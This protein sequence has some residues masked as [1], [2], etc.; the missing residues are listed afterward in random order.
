MTE[1]INK[2]LV[3][4][5]K[6]TVNFLY[7]GLV[8]FYPE[9]VF[10]SKEGKRK[11]VLEYWP[12]GGYS[13]IEFAKLLWN[14]TKTNDTVQAAQ[15]VIDWK[16]LLDNNQPLEATVPENLDAMV[17]SLE[18]NV[19]SKK[20][21]SQYDIKNLA[22][23]VLLESEKVIEKPSS[24]PEPEIAIS[25]AETISRAVGPL[26]TFAGKILTTP[27]RAATYISGPTTYSSSAK[28]EGPSVTTAR[29]M[30][31]HGI[32]SGSIRSLENRA[33]QLGIT[34]NQLRNLASLIKTEQETHPFSYK[35]ISVIYSGQKASLS[36]AQI[37]SLL[38]PSTDGSTAVL[39]GKSFVGNVL[40][41]IGQQLFGKLTS[42]ALK[43][44]GK[45]VAAK[46]ATTAA[47]QTIATAIA[48]LV[49]NIIAFVSEKI[50]GKI[51]EKFKNL[52]SKLKT[53]EGKEN[54]L[55]LI[56]GLMAIGGIIIGGPA[57]AVLVV[58]GLVPG[59]GLLV[60]KAGGFGPLG[61]S[62]GGYGQAFMAGVTGVL[63][64][65]IGMPT[66]VALVSVP[67]LIAV[68]LFI[69]NSGAYI[70]PPSPGQI[71][72]AIESPYIGIEK[73]ANP[74]KMENLSGQAT[75]TY[76]VKIFAKKGT[77]TNISITNEYKIISESSPA[78]PNPQVEE[79]KNPPKTISPTED[80]EFQYQISVG[81][82]YN[83]SVVVDSLIVVADAP[84]QQGATARESASVIIGNPPMHC[85]VP[86]GYQSGGSYT[87]G[88]ETKGHGS[89]T[90]WNAMGSRCSWRLPQ[91]VCWGPSQSIAS[92]NYCYGKSESCPY[93]GY[94]LD[95]VPT[96]SHDVFAPTVEGKSISWTYSHSF[97][98]RGTGWSHVYRGGSY[99]LVLTHLKQ[100][101]NKESLVSGE[102]VGE[103]FPQGGNTHL[104]LEFSINGQYQRPEEFFCF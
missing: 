28:G 32:S 47:T 102:K 101:A 35:W 65:S 7:T 40:G 44:V 17:S 74:V 26:S 43:A 75:I 6:K 95:V 21:L 24:I 99:Y 30:L 92:S 69:I 1:G 45:K 27:F 81:P 103:L 50:I 87:P 53:K 57:G 38:I 9:N 88:D 54:A 23:E 8:L 18:E 60:T 12:E 79:I 80:Y 63:L 56:F 51:I 97:S 14:I 13:R 82:Q 94:A 84:E 15:L 67:V 83:D 93:Y 11:P 70:V 86:G 29:Y 33:Q 78:V 19:A 36:Q 104:H 4:P 96:G 90:Y 66:I 34:P 85:P 37:S 64:P 31:S 16:N 55:A 89:N 71:P 39:P 98:N 22:K 68:I 2:K 76:S 73:E 25:S 42:K 61:S 72:G 59:L 77:L 62:I 3:P 46:V 49:G 20:K 100:S 10:S 48:P 58:G 41:R 52:I 91:G 5:S